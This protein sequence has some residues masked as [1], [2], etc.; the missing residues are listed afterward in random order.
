[1]GFVGDCV[2]ILIGCFG[3][4]LVIH[5]GIWA[6]IKTAIFGVKLISTEDVKKMA[7][8]II[9]YVDKDK[10]GYVSVYELIDMVKAWTKTN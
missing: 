6:T 5:M 2:P 7:N 4:A 1:M 3:F 10:D 8:D 9:L